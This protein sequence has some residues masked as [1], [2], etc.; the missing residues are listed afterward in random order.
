MALEGRR[1]GS[2][3][4]SLL[5]REIL[6]TAL[7]HKLASRLTSLVAVDVTPARQAG[8][9]MTQRYVPLDLPAGW[10]F[11]KVFGPAQEER[12]A[13]LDDTAR[14]RF[15]SL[16]ASAPDRKVLAPAVQ[17]RRGIDL[18]QGAT[19]ADRRILIGVLSIAFALMIAIATVAGR[20][21]LALFE[22]TASP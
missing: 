7:D 16:M 13:R 19:L 14:K 11:D 22:S 10:K 4:A 1:Y 8:A 2:S 18:P 15:A 12:D 3:S 5:D 9:P 20:R 21:A 6:R 17:T